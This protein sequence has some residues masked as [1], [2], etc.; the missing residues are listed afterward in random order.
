MKARM[1][2]PLLLVGFILSFILPI[3]LL[4]GPP[5]PTKTKYLKTIGGGFSMDSSVGALYYELHF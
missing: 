3:P 4:A 2:L 5:E 1:C